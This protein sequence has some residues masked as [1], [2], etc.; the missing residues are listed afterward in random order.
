MLTTPLH[1]TLEF[2]AQT[3]F[4]SSL[5]PWSYPV[6]RE[7]RPCKMKSRPYCL[8]AGAAANAF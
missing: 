3:A 7:A 1:G 6:H 2:G 5:S 4:L 8:I